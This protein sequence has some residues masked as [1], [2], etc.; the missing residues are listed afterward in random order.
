MKL[1]TNGTH[2]INNDSA[3]GHQAGTQ[4]VYVSGDAGGATLA[5]SYY[6]E[7]GSVVPLI[8]T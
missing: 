5:F 6:D 4:V 1:T 3:S 2:H 7:D 8:V